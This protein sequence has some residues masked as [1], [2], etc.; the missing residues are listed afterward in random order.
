MQTDSQRMNGRIDELVTKVK[1]LKDMMKGL[2]TQLEQSTS[3]MV[4]MAKHSGMDYEEEDN[5]NVGKGV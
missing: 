5:E 2:S 3:M 1:S 4:A